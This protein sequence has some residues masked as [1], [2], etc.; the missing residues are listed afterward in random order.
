M[1][2]THTLAGGA[3]ALLAVGGFGAYTGLA[4]AGAS[5]TAPNIPQVQTPAPAT[6]TG[7][8]VQQGGNTQD[9]DQNAPDTASAAETPETASAAESPGKPETPGVESD[10]PGGHQDLP[11][12]AEQT[13]DNAN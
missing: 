6:D 10:G 7:P 12:A 2:I 1:K 9:G 5:Q 8:D 11:G 4:Q 3:V 13:G